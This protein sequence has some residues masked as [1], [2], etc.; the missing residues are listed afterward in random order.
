MPQI[1]TLPS[2]LVNQIAAGEVVERPASVVKELVENSLDAGAGAITIEVD[3]GG[4]RL[5][6]VSDDGCGID[7]DQLVNAL[8]RHATSKISSLAD[9]ENI[10]SL[11]FRGE[12]LPSIAS[13]SR[14][15]LVSRLQQADGAWKL[16]ARE[17]ADPVPDALPQGTRVEVL[18]LFYNVP[19]RKK[20]LRTEQTEYKHIETLFKNMALS[21]P[22]VA[23][24][25]I[26]N[27]KTVY[28]LASVQNPADQRRRLASLC[29][30]SFAESLV[31]ID[32]SSDHLR[33]QGWV[34]LPT[35]NRS[36]ADMQ[37]FF[38]N[39]RMVRDKL[40][41]H[42]V[43]QAYQD[44]LFHGRHPAY[45][46]SLT[47]DAREL[48]VNVHPQKHEVRFRNSRM[49][50]DF[51]FRSLH[52]ALGEV[53]PEQQIDSPG[54]ALADGVGAV[55]P[56]QSV[57][58]DQS[59][60]AFNQQYRGDRSANLYDQ[61]QSYAALLQPEAHSNE[62][63][64]R[65]VQQEIPP[66]GFALA[67][68]KGIYIL[69]ENSGGLI[70]VDMHAAHERIVYE[71]MKQNAE[72]EN[73]IAQPL[74]VPIAFNVSQAEADLVEE[75]VE[76]FS[77]LGFK[78][79]RLGLEQIRLRAIPSLLKNADSEQLLRDVLAD[80]VEHGSSQRIREFQNEMLS[81]MA[82]HASVRANR[83]LSLGEMNA[84]LRDIEHT[85]R[86]GQCNHGRPTW[87]QLSLEQLDKF[88]L[89]GQ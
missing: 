45:V 41:S 21:H 35:F 71:R 85:E 54:F 67:Q 79:E 48:D 36:Q 34:A 66:L 55:Q 9:L 22:A 31:E 12:A 61:M 75:N 81:T 88:F 30:K 52:Q 16:Q 58:P 39:Q 14:L 40:I 1:N 8:S 13:V 57:Q 80:L 26:H 78:V 11:G 64:E 15:T 89:R 77:H 19:A 25:L 4:T 24:K 86:S 68:L 28:Q 59:P 56:G 3:A 73:V 46:L 69:A 33:L 65:D 23:F 50:H 38:V 17:H 60:L 62:V 43:R 83:L 2:H 53:Q 10:A 20:F 51:L 29:G 18:E 84:L 49:V 6:R 76:F 70:I 27:Q 5:I 87:K 37:Y 42:A 47:M 44:V 63:R 7:R 72:Q 32:V 82:C 74:L